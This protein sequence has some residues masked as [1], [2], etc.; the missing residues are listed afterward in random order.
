[1]D[2]PDR[3]IQEQIQVIDAAS[4]SVLDTRTL[5]S[6]SG[7]VYLQWSVTGHVQFKVTRQAGPTAIVSGL[8]LG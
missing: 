7:G 8:F 5:S 4:G 3:G 2:W 1:V 6:F